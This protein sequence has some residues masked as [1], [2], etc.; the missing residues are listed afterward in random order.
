MTQVPAWEFSLVQFPITPLQ[1]R[2]VG[3]EHRLM[4]LWRGERVVVRV[5]R[6]PWQHFRREA[7]FLFRLGRA[8][9]IPHLL[10]AAWE[11]DRKTAAIGRGYLLLPTVLGVTLDKLVREGKMKGDVVGQIWVLQRV[12]DAL[13]FAHTV[14]HGVTHQDLHPGNVLLVEGSPTSS[15]PRVPADLETSPRKQPHA[16]SPALLAPPVEPDTVEPPNILAKL[17]SNAVPSP[18]ARS[19]S[20]SSNSPATL[21]PAARKHR[22]IARSSD[23]SV[24][25][26]PISSY[27]VMVMDFAPAAEAV[28]GGRKVVSWVANNLYAGYCAPEKATASMWRKAQRARERDR[29]KGRDRDR[30]PMIP[31]SLSTHGPY[32]PRAGPAIRPAGNAYQKGRANAGTR[33][34][35]VAAAT[36]HFQ[37]RPLE[38]DVANTLT[39]DEPFGDTADTDED[40]SA[41]HDWL[42]LPGGNRRGRRALTRGG[43]ADAARM[44]SRLG[45]RKEAGAFHAGKGTDDVDR[46]YND[47]MRRKGRAAG[48]GDYGG[49]VN[50]ELENNHKH[51]HLDDANTPVGREDTASENRM[52]KIDVWSVGWLLYYMATGTHPP[53]DAWAR[54]SSMDAREL[55]DVAP[56][57]RDIIQM[58]VRRDVSKRA[59]MRDVKRRIDS[60]LQGLMFAKGVALLETERHS[61]FVLMDRAVGIKVAISC[62]ADGER[63]HVGLVRS[64]PRS[65]STS[66]DASLTDGDPGMTI[67]N[68]KAQSLEERPRTRRTKCEEHVIGLN[69]RTQAALSCL[70]LAIVRRVEW[71]AAARYLKRSAAELRAIRRALVNERWSKGEVG[72]GTMAVEY[73]ARRSEE[74]VVS[75]QSALGWIYRWGAG[76]VRKDISKAMGLWLE[77]VKARD[78]EAANGLGLLYHHGRD[79]A[80]VDGHRAR[81]Y[82]QIA[83]DEGYPAAAVNMGVMLHDGAAGLPADGVAARRLYEIA[84]ARGDAIAANNLGLLLQ[85]GAEGVERDAAKAVTAFEM[86]IELGERLHACRNL[87]DLLWA[88]ATGV[89]R[90]RKRAVELFATAIS[91]GEEGSRMAALTRLRKLLKEAEEEGEGEEEGE[92]ENGEVARGAGTTKEL[93]E[94]C[95]GLLLDA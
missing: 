24:P 84:C 35:E 11:G 27:S 7:D 33:Q 62:A 50:A 6:G 57:C 94:R 1:S 18:T 88:G 37:P 53:P 52:S 45:R 93:L 9:A 67:S 25:V 95:R 8:N 64:A 39:A 30:R 12:V 4:A 44:E 87:G 74:G 5:V 61:A 58:C 20:T 76:G 81:E 47:G 78:A 75:A 63:E 15:V 23:A 66:R 17:P 73:L 71:E 38:V 91:R 36:H 79:K 46:I 21:D 3:D 72:D 10:G 32:G 69:Q 13:V 14:E 43:A 41:N 90:D 28:D 59:C 89:G 92:E 49:G 80:P 83:V 16:H 68:M 70:P 19:P 56:G 22:R 2:S 65:Q 86:A 77:A 42:D 82:Y 40:R 34:D 48:L 54:H 55:R 60:T 85:H 29:E 26:S 51:A 31:R